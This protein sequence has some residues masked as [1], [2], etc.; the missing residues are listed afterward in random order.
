ML[1]LKPA[2]SKVTAISGRVKS[3]S[4]LL[5]RVSMVQTAGKAPM[6][7]TKPNTQDANKAPKVEKPAS[8]KI[9]VT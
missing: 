3:N 7:L 5:P 2:A 4:D 6:K 9:Y 1:K 8:E